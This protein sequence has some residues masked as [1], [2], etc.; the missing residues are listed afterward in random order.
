MHWHDSVDIRFVMAGVRGQ[1]TDSG[2]EF[3]WQTGDVM[4]Q[5]GTNHSHYQFDDE[6]CVMG[7]V[8]LGALRVGPF[9]PVEQLHPVQRGPVGGH[10]P[11]ET[12]DKGP[13]PPWTA[14]KP[15]AAESAL[16]LDSSMLKSY[17]DV[18]RPRRVVTG[19]NAEGLSY[20][21]RVEEVDEI[22]Y[23]HALCGEKS[24]HI[25]AIFPIWGADHLPE[26]LPTDGLAPRLDNHPTADGALDALHKSHVLPPPLGYRVLVV[27]LVPTAERSA[28]SWHDS[29]DVIYVMHGE[30][31]LYHDDGSEFQLGVGDTVIQNGTNHAWRNH[32][33]GDAWLGVVTLGAA[34]FGPAPPADQVH[35]VQ[36]GSAMRSG[37]IG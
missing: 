25:G 13:M 35:P 7:F 16:A 15:S 1:I 21:A 9:P 8:V 4:I 24:E 31:T 28:M 26:F 18:V 6:S 19:M 2:Q 30:V 27:K 20:L 12:R 5:N 34:R 14:P 32:G 3:V 23:E 10:R 37:E 29:Y 33:D 11:G 22:D 36:R 17:D